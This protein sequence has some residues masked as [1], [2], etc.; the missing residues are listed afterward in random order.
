MHK[1]NKTYNFALAIPRKDAG[2]VDRDGLE[3]RC[4]LTGTQGSNPCLSAT[5]TL[6]QCIKYPKKSFFG[7]I[8]LS[9]A[10][11]DANRGCPKLCN[12]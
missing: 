7:Y 9:H 1:P 12:I 2:A 6:N 8:F 5:Y 11:M 4:T 10:K 3:N